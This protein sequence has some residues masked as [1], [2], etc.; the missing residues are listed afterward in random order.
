MTALDES[1]R[2]IKIA[3]HGNSAC[4]R[5]F[6]GKIW[7]DLW[8][9]PEKVDV[10]TYAEREVILPQIVTP[11]SGPYRVGR[12][13]W[14]REVMNAWSDNEIEFVVF[15]SSAQASKTQSMTNC[16]A[17]SVAE[18]DANII[19]CF[20][21]ESLAE[22]FSDE[23]WQ[24]IVEASP[25]LARLKPA[26]RH[27]FKKTSQFFTNG[28][29]LNFVNA[30]SAT[31]LSSRPAGRVFADEI[32]KYIDRKGEGKEAPSLDLLL[33][34]LKAYK[35][36]GQIVKAFLAS[37]PTLDTG[38]IWLWYIRGTMEEYNLLCPDCGN[39]FFPE[40]KRDVCF[41]KDGADEERAKQSYLKC[42]HC[43]YKFNDRVRRKAA[44]NGEWIATN[45]NP[46]NKI[47][48]FRFNEIISTPNLADL[49]KKFL[50]A[51]RQLDLFCNPGAMQDFVNS[52]LCEIWFNHAGRSRNYDNMWANVTNLDKGIVPDN[53]IALT[54]GIDTQKDG[55]YI[56]VR[57]WCIEEVTI[58]EEDEEGNKVDHDVKRRVSHVIRNAFV[59]TFD[60]VKKFIIDDVY[61]TQGNKQKYKIELALM[62][63]G[64][65]KTQQVYR[66]CS[67]YY[68]IIV[69]TRG[70]RG[71]SQKAYFETPATIDGYEIP[72]IN[73]N[74]I[75][76]KDTL[77]IAM[78]VEPGADACMYYHREI[79]ED[80]FKQMAAEFKDLDGKWKCPK[81]KDNH[82]WDCEVLNLVAADIRG[83]YHREIEP[84]IEE[85][86][87]EDKE[88]EDTEKDIGTFG[89]EFDY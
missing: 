24:P 89:I 36:L 62:D 75:I 73:V 30:G 44:R 43:D 50:H 32:D 26:D 78:K 60:D 39:H 19:A 37:T 20:P 68:P 34:R 42:P 45:P 22:G 49:V 31:K 81:G 23:R 35:M 27:K 14:S 46:D 6:I 48:S 33:Q 1:R 3:D 74:T 40:W 11:Q 85:G 15:M 29:V 58:W 18:E 55:F 7:N 83:I 88:E 65:E 38:Q 69:P 79:T 12:T 82:Y 80:F 16:M 76:F 72:S 51:K 25:A 9:F 77:S 54:A 67:K 2:L 59:K 87:K 71:I 4:S 66:F 64:G 86:S 61:Y 5:D 84:E 56:S 41:P 70:M 13:P 8:H 17:Y 28:K 63:S 10:T 47:R 57:A 21:N 52:C 53:T